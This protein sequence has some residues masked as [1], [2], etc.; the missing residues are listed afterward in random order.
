MEFKKKVSTFE[1]YPEE[2]IETVTQPTVTLVKTA[3]SKFAY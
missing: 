3:D 1:I 2:T